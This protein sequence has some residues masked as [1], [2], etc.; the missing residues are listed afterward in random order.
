MDPK[1]SAIIKLCR[2]R[3]T[4]LDADG[5]P[6]TGSGAS[7]VSDQ[8]VSLAI[9]ADVEAA[10]RRTQRTGCDCV[11]ATDAGRATLLGFNL[12]IVSASFEPA[13]ISLLLGASPIFDEVDGDAIIGVNH[14]GGDILGCGGDVREVAFEGWAQAYSGAGVD[15]DLPWYRVIFP[16]TRWSKSPQT[17]GVE[18]SQPGLTGQVFQNGNWGSG[19]YDDMPLE[20]TLPLAVDFF[21]EF[22]TATDPPSASCALQTVS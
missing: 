16:R 18:F 9:N 1:C 11:V 10:T 5:A 7:Y 12:E 3:A 17:L 21:A 14:V 4:L 22:L 15:P 2:T 20:G 19:P 13:M 8:S 6:V